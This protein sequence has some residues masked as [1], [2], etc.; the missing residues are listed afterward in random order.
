MTD[1]IGMRW[2]C[3]NERVLP[4]T[5]PFGTDKFVVKAHMRYSSASEHTDMTWLP[6]L[7]RATLLS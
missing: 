1:E 4:A 7:A 3:W 2:K 6:S 5:M